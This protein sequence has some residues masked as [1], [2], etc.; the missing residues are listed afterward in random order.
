MLILFVCGRS[1]MNRIRDRNLTSIW[2]NRTLP[3]T[4]HLIL[5]LIHR[6]PNEIHPILSLIHLIHLILIWSIW[7]HMRSIQSWVWF[8]W[9][10]CDSSDPDL[11]HLILNVIHLI[12]NPEVT[13]KNS[14]YKYFYNSNLWQ[15]LSDK[16]WCQPAAYLTQMIFQGASC[17]RACLVIGCGTLHILSFSFTFLGWRRSINEGGRS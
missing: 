6:I 17:P 8:I 13:N 12:L 16:K 1:K 9:S 2:S 15:S 3:V 4:M 11:I 10:W 5:H 7:S 14:R